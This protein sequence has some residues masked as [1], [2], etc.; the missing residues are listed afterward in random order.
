MRNARDAPLRDVWTING[1]TIYDKNARHVEQ[2]V[3]KC[4]SGK[5]SVNK[6]ELRVDIAR[7]FELPHDKGCNHEHEAADEGKK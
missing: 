3:A 7:R 2:R 5:K 6:D 4:K 1:N